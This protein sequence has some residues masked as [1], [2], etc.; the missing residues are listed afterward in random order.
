[1]RKDPTKQNL[2]G[3]AKGQSQHIPLN[4]LA[5]FNSGLGRLDDRLRQDVR[6]SMCWKSPAWA[7]SG[8]DG[9]DVGCGR[10]Q[11]ALRKTLFEGRL[12]GKH[13]HII[14]YSILSKGNERE[15][16]QAAARSKA[17]PKSKCHGSTPVERP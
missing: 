6:E 1:M 16:L 12:C 9:T 2:S 7:E 13:D 3:Q 10:T 17:D 14:T 15:T 8:P 5:P 4:N 11:V